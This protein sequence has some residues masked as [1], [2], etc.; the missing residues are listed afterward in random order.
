MVEMWMRDCGVCVLWKL[1]K[2][3]QEWWRGGSKEKERE[4]GGIDEM[5]ERVVE[6]IDV[7]EE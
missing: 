6:E 1:E 4:S 5:E 2:L 3:R 7:L